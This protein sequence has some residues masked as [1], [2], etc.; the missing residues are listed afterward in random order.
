MSRD[1]STFDERLC[2]SVIIQIQPDT[3]G[4]TGIG[5]LSILVAQYDYFHKEIR[6]RM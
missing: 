5:K 6:C 4:K 1:N 3:P 2:N